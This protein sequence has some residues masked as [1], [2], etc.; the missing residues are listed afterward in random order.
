MKT[1]SIIAKRQSTVRDAINVLE[2]AYMS[3]L[4]LKYVTKIIKTPKNWKCLLIERIT[5]PV[6]PLLNINISETKK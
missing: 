5:S 6:R 3:F 2:I 1:Y 4:S